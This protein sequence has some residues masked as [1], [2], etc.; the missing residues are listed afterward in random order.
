[1]RH[2]VEHPE[3]VFWLAPRCWTPRSASITIAAMTKPEEREADEVEQLRRLVDQLRQENLELTDQMSRDSLTGLAS[4]R[5]FDEQAAAVLAA[6][7]MAAIT[8]INL[9]RFRKVN[10]R[11]GHDVGDRLLI[12]VAQRLKSSIRS[13]AVAARSSGDVFALVTPEVASEAAALKEARAICAVIGAP[14]DLDGLSIEVIARAGLAVGPQH[15]TTID[16]L[17]QRADAAMYQ[18]KARKRRAVLYTLRRDQHT[19]P[20]TA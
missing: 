18:A 19:K 16:L 20:G 12:E 13:S 9:N 6:G 7:G 15:G 4:R 17:V 8:L 10:H 1:L 3:Q 5:E 14:Y 2:L 11:F